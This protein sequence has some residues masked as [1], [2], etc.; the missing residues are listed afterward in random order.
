VRLI[1]PILVCVLASA[2][3]LGGDL[4]SYSPAESDSDAAGGED[5]AGADPV[6][7]A[8]ADLFAD[9]PAPDA[10]DTSRQDTAGM[11]VGEDAPDT[12]DA[13]DLPPSC[14]ELCEEVDGAV[15]SSCQDQ[16]CVWICQER[17]VDLDGDLRQ[18]AEGSGCE[19]DPGNAEACG[20]GID[21]DCDGSIDEGCCDSEGWASIPLPP[22][23]AATSPTIAYS[24]T[25]SMLVAW[26]LDRDDGTRVQS[27]L[28]RGSGLARVD[29]PMVNGGE[30]ARSPTATYHD[31]EFV[32]GWLEDHEDGDTLRFLSYDRESGNV[33]LRPTEFSSS[34]T[35][36][37]L[38][39]ARISSFGQD[40]CAAWVQPNQPPGHPNRCS[41]RSE[42]D[43]QC[44]RFEVRDLGVDTVET[45]GSTAKLTRP[46]IAH[47]GDSAVV[48][49]N[50]LS[51]NREMKMN[52]MSVQ[53]DLEEVS[54]DS[55][56]RDPIEVDSTPDALALNNGRYVTAFYDVEELRLSVQVLPRDEG[57]RYIPVGS[58]RA[59]DPRFAGR[60]QR[61]GIALVWR[62]SGVLLSTHLDAD[63]TPGAEGSLRRFGPAVTEHDVSY[64]ASGDFGVI[65]VTETAI[66]VG[67]FDSQGAALCQQ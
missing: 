2:C 8:P 14:E 5:D 59:R 57:T 28:F 17:L 64:D 55:V 35:G 9:G 12:V 21:N 46:R 25:G 43:D 50:E 4:G 37:P 22:D 16:Q 7:D 34:S 3:S 54:E 47:E 20:D 36:I 30:P 40:L 10:S 44:V 38:Q 39:S 51:R 13:P 27:A 53:R 26:Q 49:Y 24:D 29:L 11:D 65:A 66:L 18:G 41:G 33:S 6:T 60:S 63:M 52:F 1:A 31:G 62:D 45:E 15:A 19:C 23:V 48:I 58:S 67:R 32:L 42:P 61:D 56:S